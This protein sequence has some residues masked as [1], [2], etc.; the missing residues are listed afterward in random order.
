M[1]L[2]AGQIYEDAAGRGRPAQTRGSAPLRRVFN[3]TGAVSFPAL[4][5]GD[6]KKL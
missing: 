6:R 5:G 3:F 2:P 1:A 4:A